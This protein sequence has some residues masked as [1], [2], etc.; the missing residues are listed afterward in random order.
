MKT[1]RFERVEE[2]YVT[3]EQNIDFLKED[4]DRD[5]FAPAH[6]SINATRLTEIAKEKGFD[7]WRWVGFEKDGEVEVVFRKTFAEDENRMTAKQAQRYTAP[8][9]VQSWEEA[10][11]GEGEDE[12]IIGTVTFARG[13][14]CTFTD[15]AEFV[16]TIRE[17]LPD[18]SSSG[19]AFKV[20]SDDAAMRMEIDNLVY[21]EYGEKNPHDL[22]YYHAHPICQEPNCN[23]QAEVPM[24]EP[25]E[26]M[27]YEP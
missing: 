14:C 2:H 5:I 11:C 24:H 25:E 9:P 1:Q 17:E 15:S 10:G 7:S 20:L 26:D 3:L 18:R 22:L 6:S 19:F 23:D 27:E 21:N 12:K 4:L 16:K 8:M 13:N